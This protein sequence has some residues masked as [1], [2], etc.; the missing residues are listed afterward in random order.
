M[1]GIAEIAM[2]KGSAIGKSQTAGEIAAL[3][4]AVEEL[5]TFYEAAEELVPYYE[6]PLHKRIVTI[7]PQPVADI[8][9]GTIS[10]LKALLE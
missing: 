9:E 5:K 6:L 2:R 1:S 7:D 8:N 3:E 10:K 4:K